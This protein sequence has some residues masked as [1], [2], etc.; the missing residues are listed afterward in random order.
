MNIITPETTTLDLHGH[1][2]SLAVARIID[3]RME[4]LAHIHSTAADLEFLALQRLA[5]P[6]MP[7]I[8]QVQRERES[9]WML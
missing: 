9:G 1:F 5:I 8:I 2:E 7:Y 3:A 6:L 4:Q